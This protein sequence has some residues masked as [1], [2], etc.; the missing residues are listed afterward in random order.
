MKFTNNLSEERRHWATNYLGRKANDKA[1][2]G[3]IN[4]SVIFSISTLFKHYKKYK[5]TRKEKKNYLV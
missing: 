2:I 5:I 4:L 1:S 3:S